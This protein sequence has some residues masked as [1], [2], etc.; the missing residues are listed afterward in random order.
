MPLIHFNHLL[1]QIFHFPKRKFRKIHINNSK[2]RIF[3]IFSQKLSNFAF[4]WNFGEFRKYSTIYLGFILDSE[5]KLLS[6]ID[7]I[8]KLLG[9]SINALR[10][11]K[12]S[13]CEKS[14][15]KFFHAHINSNIS[16]CAFALLRCR[17]IDIERL[18]RLQSKAL[19]I[20][21]EVSDMFPSSELFTS[22]APN[23]LPVTVLIYYSAIMLVKKSL[24]WDGKFLPKM[25]KLKTNRRYE[26]KLCNARKQILE[27]DITFN[28][29][30]LFN[31][32]PNDI[33]KECNFYEFKILL[34]KYLLSRNS[35][36]IK[37]GQFTS[38]RL[39][40]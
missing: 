37:P 23:I 17:S 38:Q 39:E 33:K 25:E 31:Q 35:S 30:K 21:F 4:V 6:Q 20:I 15:L 11:L 28:G 12:S 18:Q 14:L 10:H 1:K 34:K 24:L 9:Q 36:L 40:L 3:P 16:Y 7:K 2:F 5:L 8:V 26:I 19:R 29:V 13:L 32:L 27:D 22:K